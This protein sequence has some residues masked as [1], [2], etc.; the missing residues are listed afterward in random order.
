[1]GFVCE[2]G[3]TVA[4]RYRLDRLLGEGGMGA[5]WA[6]THTVTRKAVALKFL[7]SMGQTNPDVRRRFLREARAASVLRH[8]N[9]LQVHDIL[10]LE[11][12]A[13]V[14]V[15]DL[16]EGESLADKLARERT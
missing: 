14:M 11:D 6:A 15:M 13:P 10:E 12:G 5:V 1:M 2:Q 4:R 3:A 7:K 8:P 16:L 9:V